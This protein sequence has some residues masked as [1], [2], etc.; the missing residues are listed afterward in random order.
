V[1]GARYETRDAARA[2]VFEY[3]EVFYNRVRR[4]SSL[5]GVSPAQFYAA[6]TQQSTVRQAA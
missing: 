2:D 4:H 3:I 1:H 5:A 6:W